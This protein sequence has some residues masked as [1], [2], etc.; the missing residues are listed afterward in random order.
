MANYWYCC[1]K[2]GHAIKKESSPNTSGCSRAS[3]HEWIRLGEVGDINYSCK[4]CGLTV[5]TKSSPSTSGCPDSSYH[6]WHRL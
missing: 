2:C 5:Q 4:K 1:R 6:E 3:Y